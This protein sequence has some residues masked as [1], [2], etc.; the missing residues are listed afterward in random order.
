MADQFHTAIRATA[1]FLLQQPD[2]LE[3]LFVAYARAS[4]RGTSEAALLSSLQWW[5]KNVLT[6]SVPSALNN[7]SP[8]FIKDNVVHLFGSKR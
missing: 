5:V 3:G 7:L 2:V 6:L 1:P 8:D 4:L